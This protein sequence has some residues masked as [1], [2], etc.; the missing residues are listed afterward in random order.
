MA[1]VRIR[2]PVTV[3]APLRALL[4]ALLWL[5]F[6]VWMTGLAVGMAGALLGL[7]TDA[8]LAGWGLTR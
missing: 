6:V 3:V 8:F 7:L 4:R 5:A 2:K 1:T